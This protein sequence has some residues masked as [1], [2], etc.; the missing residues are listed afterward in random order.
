MVFLVQNIN[1]NGLGLWLYHDSC[2]SALRREI[3]TSTFCR[4]VSFLLTSWAR[5]S[6]Q[7]CSASFK[8]AYWALSSECCCISRWTLS[9]RTAKSG[10]FTLPPVR[11]CSHPACACHDCKTEPC[12]VIGVNL[13]QHAPATGAP[14]QYSSP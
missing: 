14:S 1:R 9:A 7:R 13:R 12:I 6:S 4:A 11:T 3:I 8:A 10:F 5:S 2:S